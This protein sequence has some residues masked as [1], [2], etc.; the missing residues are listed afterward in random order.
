MSLLMRITLIASFLGTIYGCTSLTTPSSPQPVTGPKDKP[1]PEPVNTAPFDLML[2]DGERVSNV[3]TSLD[4]RVERNSALACL[5]DVKFMVAPAPGACITSGFGPRFGTTHKGLDFQGP[6]RS[7]VMVVAAAAGT[8]VINK[9]RDDL[10]H[11]IVLDHGN[12]IYTGYGHLQDAPKQ[13]VNSTVN[14]EEPLAMMGATGKAARGKL[15]L[16]VEFAKGM[17][18]QAEHGG[19][20]NLDRFDPLVLPEDC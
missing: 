12:G 5:Q 18:K 1:T 19:Y 16:H 10:G 7:A 13:A 4:S 20:F 3:Q 11:W 6:G 14:A 17:L 8:V 9:W 2:C 15:H